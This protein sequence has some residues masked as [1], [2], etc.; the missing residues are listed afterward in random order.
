M[1]FHLAAIVSGLTGGLIGYTSV[2]RSI[3]RLEARLGVRLFNRTTRS[4]KLT[5]GGELYHAQ[6]QQALEQIAVDG[7]P[8]SVDVEFRSRPPRLLSAHLARVGD[9]KDLLVLLRDLTREQAVDTLLSWTDKPRITPP[10]AWVNEPVIGGGKLR[11][12]SDA[13]RRAFQ[14]RNVARGGADRG[15]HDDVVG[16]GSS[17]EGDA[18]RAPGPSEPSR[19]LD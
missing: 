5:A 11:E 9:G 16:G 17:R 13:E 10:P 1:I 14:R 6:C 8:I 4:V 18:D 7:Q 2:S 12:M 19:L 15:P 3:G